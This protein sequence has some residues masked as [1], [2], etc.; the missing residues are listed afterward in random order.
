M[1]IIDERSMLGLDLLASVERVCNE[2]AHGGSN[3]EV[4]FGGI[5]IILVFGDDYQL[6]PVM[7]K[8][9][10]DMYNIDGS[11]NEE[12]D[13]DDNLKNGKKVMVEVTKNVRSLT[14][15]ERIQSSEDTL[16]EICN[17][18]RNTDGLSLNLAQHLLKFKLDNPLISDARREECYN[19]GLWV[20]TTTVEVDNFNEERMKTLVNRENPLMVLN[21]SLTKSDRSTKEHTVQKHFHKKKLCTTRIALC[22]GARVAIN[23]NLWIE[24]GLFNGALGTVV[25]I[26]FHKGHSPLQSDLPAYVIV[27]MDKY[28]GP[29]WD[30][31]NPLH[32]PIPI[33]KLYCSRGGCCILNSVPLELSFART[34][35]KVQGQTIGPGHPI[36]IMI[37][38]PGDTSFEGNNPGILYTGCSRATTLGGDDMNKSALYLTGKGVNLDR[39]MN[40]V[41]KRVGGSNS[42]KRT[43]NGN[44]N[45]TAKRARMKYNKVTKREFFLEYLDECEK[46]TKMTLSEADKFDIRCWKDNFDRTTIDTDTLN[47]IIAYHRYVDSLSSYVKN[48]SDK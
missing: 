32:V 35:H 8:G 36:E 16:R 41:Y 33:S 42:N 45:D 28:D 24:V 39:F 3:D 37:F 5:P 19:K 10:F 23:R 18:L 21:H 47:R 9:A 26:R 44:Y 1:L 40:L 30:P 29:S 17:S 48:N 15:I 6:P 2:F 38:S 43:F 13:E 14:Q 46:N 22:R 34:L 4:T 7:T 31:D 20:F 27:E 11:L 25:D 12:I